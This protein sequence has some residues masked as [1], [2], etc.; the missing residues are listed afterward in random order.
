MPENTIDLGGFDMVIAVTENAINSQFD[1]LFYDEIIP[2]VVKIET[3][4]AS[5]NANLKVPVLRLFPPSESSNGNNENYPCLMIGFEDGEFKQGEKTI[6]LE[7]TVFKFKV[8]IDQKKVEKTKLLSSSNISQETKSEVEKIDDSQ[9]DIEQIYI[10]ISKSIRAENCWGIENFR[11]W[12][13]IG[14]IVD[15]MAKFFI[16]ESNDAARFSL[17]FHPLITAQSLAEQS[18]WPSLQPTSLQFCL[19]NNKKQGLNTLNY[20]MMTEER[21]PPSA[22]PMV[23]L[24]LI[25]GDIAGQFYISESSWKLRGMIQDLITSNDPEEGVPM[26]YFKRISFEEYQL[27][28]EVQ[29]QTKSLELNEGSLYRKVHLE[30]TLKY[31]KMTNYPYDKCM[32]LNYY[33]VIGKLTFE[34]STGDLHSYQ[35]RLAFKNILFG[36]CSSLQ[37]KIDHFDYMSHTKFSKPQEYYYDPPFKNFD[38][39]LKEISN[40]NELPLVS[41]MVKGSEKEFDEFLEYMLLRPDFKNLTAHSREEKVDF[42]KPIFP[43]E[44]NI[45]FYK[46]LIRHK[47]NG[48]SISMDLKYK[49]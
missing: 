1:S 3:E 29:L 12:S 7:H 2:N 43:S 27:E 23:N 17:G 16:E 13:V 26:E 37:L 36:I 45:F 19:Q 5:L 20:V 33:G 30:R 48:E 4:Q 11:D 39:G 22:P 41:A 46:N 9:F 28:K 15:L 14:T 24:P 8:T 6:K 25:E 21:K 38:T 40:W 47:N 10:S 32:S 31:F 42:F 35:R 18:V 44:T 49:E 34:T